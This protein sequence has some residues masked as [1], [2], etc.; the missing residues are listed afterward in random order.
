MHICNQSVRAVLLSFFLI[1][2]TGFSHAEPAEPTAEQTMTFVTIEAVPWAAMDPSTGE[3]F[4]A[5][6]EIVDALE[7]RTGLN[8]QTSLTPFARIDR[9]METG[10]HDC[11]I[12]IP[13]DK[14]LVSRGETLVTHDIGVV[15][16]EE[17]PINSFE[18]LRNKRLSIPRGS[19]IS[20]VLEGD[21]N[22]Q[23]EQDTD[24]LMALRK[25][26]RG[27]IDG[28]AGAVPTIF[29]IA[30][31]HDLYDMLA[32]SFKLSDVPLMFQCSWKSEKLDLMP[33]L[34]EAIRSMKEDGSLE[35]ISSKHE[36]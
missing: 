3:P 1:S 18:T 22:L 2:L 11:T 29:Y 4:G 16:L 27:R 30:K 10:S 36:F 21:Y 15:S 32:P 26:Q 6:V 25:L 5:F 31:K 19:S 28:I 33:V 14:S 13:R 8:I 34:N 9:E 24:Y 20:Q 12:A 35:A 7:Q 17:A 23:L